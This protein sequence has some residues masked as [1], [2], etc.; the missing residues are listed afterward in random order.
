MSVKEQL[1]KILIN[2]ENNYISG[3]NLATSLNVS[4]NSIWKA[5]KS[6]END[7]YVIEAIRNKGYCLLS[8]NDVLSRDGVLKYLNKPDFFDIEVYKE[9]TSTNTLLKENL[10][11]K[12][13]KVLVSSHQTNGLGRLSRNF[14]SPKDTGVYFSFILRPNI[15]MSQSTYLTAMT[16][17]AV[18]R[19]IFNVTQKNSQ[20]KWV[21]D[22]FLDDKKVCGILCEA[23]FS[24]ENASLEYVILGIGINVYRPK[25]GFPEEIEDIAGFILENHIDDVRNKLVAQVLNNFYSL[26]QEFDTKKI[27]EEYKSKSYI[28]G[29][30]IYVIKSNEN[31]KALALDIDDNCGLVVKYEDGT[32]ETLNSGE[33]ST[34]I[35]K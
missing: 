33:I 9:V 5:I 34:K 30:E 7:G 6:L 15:T 12:E 28:L 18:S 27:V 3:E 14:H 20:V 8:S 35:I 19:A 4:R 11:S 29:K 1:L 25:D 17:I 16:S 31:T 21:N 24:M 10:N 13:W 32:I 22:I 23:S 2:Q 26:Y